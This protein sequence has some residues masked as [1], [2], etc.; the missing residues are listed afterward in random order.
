MSDF[1]KLDKLMLNFLWENSYVRI[2]RERSKL[3][4][5]K[6]GGVAA[7]ANITTHYKVPTMKPV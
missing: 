1:M 6:P 2:A 4:E 7:L 3:G 5:E